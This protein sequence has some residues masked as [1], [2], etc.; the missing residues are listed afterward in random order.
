MNEIIKELKAQSGTHSPSIATLKAKLPNLEIK[1]DA[2]F[3]SNPYA[4]DLF[5][6][7]MKHDLIDKD[8][9]RDYLEFYP[10]QNQVIAGRLAK[11]LNIESEKLLIGNGA[12][13][14]IEKVLSK[15]VK[16]GVMVIIPTFSSYYEFIPPEIN[17]CFYQLKKEDNYELNVDDYIAHVK[18]HKDEVDTIVLI[19]PNNP[20]GSFL[21]KGELTKIIEELSFLENVIVD[22]SFIHFAY[23]SE[24]NA[25]F[26]MVKYENIVDLHDGIIIIKSMSKDFG[27]AGIRAGYCIMNAK[28]IE[29][30]LSYGFLWNSSGL[31]EYFFDKYVEEEF[32]REY[33][34]IRRQY[35]GETI[36]FKKALQQI[37]NIVVYPG[38]ANFYLVEVLNKSSIDVF[39]E[40]L[41]HHGVYVRNCDDKIG[42]EKGK[43]LRIASRS[44]AENAIIVDSL[45]QVLNG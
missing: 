7:H 26:K 8:K 14:L 37:E 38:K 35:I 12:I 3:L 34:E 27:V 1:V 32:Q 2:C 23:E 10:S 28:K 29:Q 13:E 33:T 11:A 20:N 30:Y 25:E 15:E 19:N 21:N 9:F 36:D 4:T 18:A 31:A 24:G 44:K 41:L 22:E 43:Y 42:L 40:L 45:N 39:L 16:K 6:K 5:F 17:K